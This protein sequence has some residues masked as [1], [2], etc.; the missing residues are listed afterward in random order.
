[1]KVNKGEILA[2]H[3]EEKRWSIASL[4]KIIAAFVVGEDVPAKDWP[5]FKLVIPELFVRFE[6]R[7]TNLKE[8]YAM[9]LQDLF[10]ALL[11]SSG[12][13]A[14]QALSQIFYNGC[15]VEGKIISGP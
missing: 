7:R 15:D 12:N 13:D 10:H 8:G 14:A 5:H 1:M 3:M 9:T 2:N 4:T 6:E 11:V